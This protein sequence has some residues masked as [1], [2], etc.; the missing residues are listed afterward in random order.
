MSKFFF[1]HVIAFSIRNNTNTNSDAK[2]MLVVIT[3]VKTSKIIDKL[4]TE[5]ELHFGLLIRRIN[6]LL[7]GNRYTL[8]SSGNTL[9]NHYKKRPGG[10]C[11]IEV[12]TEKKY[13]CWGR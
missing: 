5:D 8:T 7:S 13:Q 10:Q 2:K 9:T 12:V 1:M 3:V 6:C 11:S 4:L